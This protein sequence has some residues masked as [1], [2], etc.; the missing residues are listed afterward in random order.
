[1]QLSFRTYSLVAIAAGFLLMLAPWQASAQLDLTLK[2]VANNWPTIELYYTASCDGEPRLDLPKDSIRI[3]ENGQE[4]REFTLWCPPD[5]PDYPP[6]SIAFV[7]DNSEDVSSSLRQEQVDALDYLVKFWPIY[8]KDEMTVLAQDSGGIAETPINAIPEMQTSFAKGLGSSGPSRLLDVVWHAVSKLS[9]LRQYP[10]NGIIIFWGADD[11]LSKH[12][13]DEI[14]KIRSWS[15]IYVIALTD[16]LDT[17]IPRLLVQWTSGVFYPE[18]SIDN[19]NKAIE[20]LLT[21]NTGGYGWSECVSTYQAD[22]MDGSIRTVELVLD[23][24][25]GETAADVK[26]FRAPLDTSANKVL[27]VNLPPAVGSPGGKILIPVVLDTLTRYHNRLTGARFNLE[28]DENVLEFNG[29]ELA[30]TAFEGSNVTYS[31]ATKSGEIEAPYSIQNLYPG[32]PLFMMEF[33]IAADA[34]VGSST[35]LIMGI[36]DYGGC[37]WPSSPTGIVDIQSRESLEIFPLTDTERCD[38][39]P[40]VLRANNG[41]LDYT[42][43]DGTA[44]MINVIEQSG[45]Y[46]VSAR[47]SSGAGFTSA[48]VD[49]VFHQPYEPQIQISGAP[50]FCGGDSITL[51]LADE[52]VSYKWSTGET[53]PLIRAKSSRFYSVTLVDSN[54]CAH[55]SNR[56]D[57]PADSISDIEIHGATETCPGS[58]QSYFP[59]RIAD[60]SYSWSV[61]NGSVVDI[62]DRP[63]YRYY[64][65]YGVLVHWNAE[66]I[67]K[68]VLRTDYRGCS[69]YDTLEVTIAEP[70]DIRVQVD[71]PGYVC[72]GVST[73]ITAP[74]DFDEY[75][76]SDGNRY[77]QR[78]VYRAGEYYVR[79]L[80]SSGC[81]VISDTV[82]IIEYPNPDKPEIV[83]VGDK[84]IAQH[85]GQR[86]QW[87][88]DRNWI[89]GATSDTLFLT[90][91]GEYT[92]MTWNE[93]G[94]W[95][96]S[97]TIDVTIL[98][99]E[100]PEAPGS[101]DISLSPV[102]A[103]DVLNVRVLG[104]NP[105]ELEFTVYSLLGTEMLRR[106]GSRIVS[107]DVA[108][109]TPGVY[110][111]RATGNGRPVVKTFV[112]R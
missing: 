104:D 51:S 93:F 102:P 16:S 69:T 30:G 55:E 7:L 21:Y 39:S 53:T 61:V 96:R 97:D 86:I 111:L 8:A 3:F 62:S 64:Y 90:R 26:T 49:V 59:L 75:L 17:T 46:H 25:C 4:V 35:I 76:W 58:Y 12:S 23:K 43:S 57:V 67:G 60:A 24:M 42:W 44:G 56:V 82:T 34:A 98:S 47:D 100:V 92:A 33:T 19:L 20:H 22:C 77:P 2:R 95:A 79:C 105:G 13:I 10:T 27:A 87:A 1:M 106:N 70:D 41:Y 37:W 45:T 36:N 9:L 63:R 29:I 110:I 18:F 65:Y 73:T 78:R 80:T 101:F 31:S 52:F 85:S 14:L 88:D 107:L 71:G 54:G 99:A 74:V 6:A 15:P 84:L 89:E 68:V 40:V 103:D 28:Y 48:P 94:C 32:L 38:S 5:K 91:P 81:S 112:K 108:R 72:Q 50:L 83:R 66:G 11:S 109:L